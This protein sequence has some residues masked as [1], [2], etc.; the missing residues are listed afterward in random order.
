MSHA[1]PSN[2]KR[3]VDDG[4]LVLDYG[5]Q[6]TLLI[7]RRLRELGV[8]AEVIDGRAARRPEGFAFHGVILGGGPDTVTDIGARKLPAWV[9]ESKKPVLGICYGLHLLVEHFGGK[10][11]SGKG[12][13]YGRAVLQL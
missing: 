10:M 13:E 12:R 7:A 4:I 11:R 5:S 3:P 2:L 1:V 8:Y 9:L 6:Y